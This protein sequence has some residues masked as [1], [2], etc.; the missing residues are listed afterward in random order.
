MISVKSYKRG[1]ET[2][3]EV[4]FCGHLYGLNE[5]EYQEL[6]K[7]AAELIFADQIKTVSIS[8]K[9][10]PTRG[11]KMNGDYEK[12]CMEQMRHDEEMCILEEMRVLKY[13]S[14]LKPKFSRD[15]N[16]Y[17]YLHGDNLHEGIAGF[18]ETA[19]KAAADF[20]KNYTVVKKT[21]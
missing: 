4:K 1:S 2:R 17:C 19:Y 10:T 16:M 5:T 21:A 7:E 3:Y 9:A 20:V 18:G 15:G 8:P 11:E 13:I 14:I 12:Q 6:L